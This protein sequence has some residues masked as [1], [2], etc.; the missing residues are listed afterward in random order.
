MTG[1]MISEARCS[2]EDGELHVSTTGT[3]PPL[4]LIGGGVGAADDYR[5]LVKLFNDEYTV[6]CYDR[7]GHFRSTDRTEGPIAVSRHADDAHAVLEHLGSG[8]ATVFGTSAGALI[9]L[10]LI[11]RHPESV[12]HLVAHEPP[13]VRLMPDAEHWLNAAAEQVELARAGDLMAAFS[14]FTSAIAGAS[15]PGLPMVRLS[16]K[17]EWAFFFERE[18]AAFLDYLP[19]MAALRKSGIDITPIAGE[20]SRGR[21]HY[22]PAKLLALELGQPFVEVPGSHLAPQRHPTQLAAAL[23]SVFTAP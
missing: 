23:R 16:N 20:G 21:Y 13:V 1:V 5:A 9:G 17:K 22:Q 8:K 4:L 15:L 3:G 18:L 7:R 2:V 12:L 6:V 11:V 19:E 10:E 14:S